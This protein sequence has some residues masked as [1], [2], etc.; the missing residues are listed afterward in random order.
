MADGQAGA[1]PI[2]DSLIGTVADA[3]WSSGMNDGDYLRL[4][5][6][7]CRDLS[8]FVLREAMSLAIN[9]PDNS[10]KRLANAANSFA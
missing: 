5:R 3:L 10:L 4:S 6:S 7:A 2:S 8:S 1:L 9:T